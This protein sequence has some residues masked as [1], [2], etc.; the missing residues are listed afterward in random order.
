M[1]NP[2]VPASAVALP[3]LTRRNLLLGL[4][5]A[6]TGAGVPA[7]LARAAGDADAA[8]TALMGTFEQ[9]LAA[10]ETARRYYNICERRYFDLHPDPPKALTVRGRLGHLLYSRW[11]VWQAAD[12]RRLL[13]D[14]K[15]RAL[16]EAARAALPLARAYEAQIKA[17]KRKTDVVAAEAG[18]NAAIDRV[19]E[20]SKAILAA[21]ARAV[22]GLAVK[23]RV[24]KRWGKPEWWSRGGGDTYERLAA[25]IIDAV[26]AAADY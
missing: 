11:D 9:S 1:P 14:R 8:L 21:P 12:L 24:V 18:N 25:Q 6:S 17:A 7:G 22:S 13:K 10:Y 5:A 23:A 26:I 15:Q 4:A 16:W 2:C 19:A 20:V 3:S